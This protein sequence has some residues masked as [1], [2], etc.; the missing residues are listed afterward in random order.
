MA[1]ELFFFGAG[2]AVLVT[3]AAAVVAL[4]R[5]RA[6]RKKLDARKAAKAGGTKA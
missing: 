4:L 5:M 3:A 2:L 6:Y 1:G